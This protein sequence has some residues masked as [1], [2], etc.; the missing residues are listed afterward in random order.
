L[1]MAKVILD[2]DPAV[3]YDALDVYFQGYREFPNMKPGESVQV[4]KS[5]VRYTF[6]MNEDSHT[7]EQNE[8]EFGNQDWQ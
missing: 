3:L 7:V 5:S 6:T 1:I 2:A 4:I 8:I